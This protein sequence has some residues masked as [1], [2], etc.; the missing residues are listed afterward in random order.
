M[1]ARFSPPLERS[2]GG[3]HG[4]EPYGIVSTTRKRAVLLSMRS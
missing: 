1:W 4:L 2:W 3:P